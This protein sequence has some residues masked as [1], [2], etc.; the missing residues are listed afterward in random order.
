[1]I[2]LLRR[3]DAA[4]LP[5]VVVDHAART[6]LQTACRQHGLTLCIEFGEWSMARLIDALTGINP[7]FRLRP[8]PAPIPRDPAELASRRRLF[9]QTDLGKLDLIDEVPPV[10]GFFAAF[11]RSHTTDHLGWPVNVLAR[12]R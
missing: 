10:G 2:E 4:G 12:S 8:Q 9:L 3:L 1:M 11:A 6:D 5:F 7:V